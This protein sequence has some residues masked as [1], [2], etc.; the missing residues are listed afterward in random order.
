MESARYRL[1][2]S[3]MRASEY[4]TRMRSSVMFVDLLDI[5]RIFYVVKF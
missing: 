4:T 2:D 3:R 5:V 1:E